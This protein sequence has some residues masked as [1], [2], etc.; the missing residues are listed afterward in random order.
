MVPHQMC[1]EFESVENRARTPTRAVKEKNGLRRLECKALSATYPRIGSTEPRRRREK[2]TAST[3]NLPQTTQDNTPPG[4]IFNAQVL[5]GRMIASPEKSGV[6][7]I[8]S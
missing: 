6:G 3:T 1:T 4:S 2:P 7:K 8:S 5:H